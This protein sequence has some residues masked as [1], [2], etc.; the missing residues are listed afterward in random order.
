MKKLIMKQ[1]NNNNNLQFSITV[2]VNIFTH[3]FRFQ[4]E[5][6]LRILIVQNL[7]P[8]RPIFFIQLF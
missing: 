3:L 7:G 1:S 4:K 5:T 2:S 8:F 6:N